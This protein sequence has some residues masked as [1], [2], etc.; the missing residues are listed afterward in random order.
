MACAS[1][2]DTQARACLRACAFFG[3]CDV[4]AR[5]VLGKARKHGRAYVLLLVIVRGRYAVSLLH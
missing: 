4:G 1:Y 5:S 2:I 3:W